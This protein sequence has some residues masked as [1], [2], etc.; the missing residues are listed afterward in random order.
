MKAFS[1]ITKVLLALCGI[2]IAYFLLH[3]K[4]ATYTEP[5]DV[6]S[7]VDLDIP[8]Y[9]IVSEDN[10]LD[11]GASRWNNFRYEITYPL[12]DTTY[13]LKQLR[14]NDWDLEGERY[15]KSKQI[16]E[17]LIYSVIVLN[18]DPSVCPDE[19][20]A[21]L[22]VDIDELYN[23]GDIF[24]IIVITFFGIFWGVLYLIIKWIDKRNKQ[25]L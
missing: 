14:S 9:K 11:R 15:W 5:N 10:N 17:D 13:I 1:L 20:R 22:E 24:M 16:D 12:K 21:F 2:A 3:A 25:S 6:L 18:P 4:F 7:A 23:L 8:E 19:G